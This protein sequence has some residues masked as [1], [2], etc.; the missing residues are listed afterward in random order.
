M[1]LC[2]DLGSKLTNRDDIAPGL[3]HA[4]TSDQP[5]NLGPETITAIPYNPTTTVIQDALVGPLNDMQA[6]LHGLAHLLPAAGEDPV[7]P[8][9]THPS[10]PDA[11]D[12]AG[13]ALAEIKNGL[14][15]FFG[16]A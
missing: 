5:T 1:R 14:A 4:L 8:E 2:F 15:R 13:E 9:K 3:D 12:T 11:P 10:P 16:T 6:A 7:A